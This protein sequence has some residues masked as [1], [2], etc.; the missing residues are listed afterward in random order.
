MTFKENKKPK[1]RPGE[2]QTQIW[3]GG[4]FV[5]GKNFEC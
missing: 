1:G 3:C 5:F 4:F 2:M